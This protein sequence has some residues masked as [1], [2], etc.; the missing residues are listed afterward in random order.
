M[1]Q[2]VYDQDILSKKSLSSSFL[3]CFHVGPLCKDLWS[4]AAHPDAKGD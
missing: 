2:T 3:L 4:G 1:P